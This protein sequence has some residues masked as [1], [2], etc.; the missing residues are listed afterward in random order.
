MTKKLDAQQ[1]EN[2]IQEI[3]CFHYV[4]RLSFKGMPK[5][6]TTVGGF[7]TIVL[8]LII[9][10]ILGDQMHNIMIYEGY[11]YRSI[12]TASNHTEIGAIK[13]EDMKTLPFFSVHYRGKQLKIKDEETCAE[14]DGDCYAFVNKY[15]DVKWNNAK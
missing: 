4:P 2:L 15:L 10:A 1:N 12:V 3:D 6:G 13:L 9:L 11:Y 5:Q 8:G 7:C 14:T